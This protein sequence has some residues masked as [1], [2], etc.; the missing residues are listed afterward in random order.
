MNDLLH[1]YAVNEPT[2]F[3]LSLLLILAV[4]F[5]FNRVWSVRNLDLALLL[6]LSPGLLLLRV[7]DVGA[8][9]G[10]VWLFVVSSLIL[11]RLC[12]D[13]FLTRRPRLEQNLNAPGL[14]FL[15]CAALAFLTTRVMLESPHASAVATVRSAEDLLKRV[16]SSTPGEKR[17]QAGPATRLLAAPVVPLSEVVASGNGP[18][19]PGPQG[20]EAIAARTL[21]ILCHAAVVLGLILLGRW[22]LGDWQLGLAMATLYLL[23]PCTAYDVSQVNHVLPAALIVWAFVAWKRPMVAGVLLGLACGTLFFAA[24]LLPL[25][26]A[27]Y[28]RRGALRFALALGLVGAVLLG[29][30]VLTSADTHSFTRQT[31]GSIDWS[32]LRFQGTEDTGFWSMYDSAYRIPVFAAFVIMLVVVSIWPRRK[33]LEHLMAHSAA[34]VV[35]TQFWYP[36]QGGVYVLWYL[37]LLLMVFF[38]PRVPLLVPGEQAPEH[39]LVRRA[40]P[41]RQELVRTGISSSQFFR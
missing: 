14:A 8:T 27:F 23:L 40:V 19:S 4:F 10:Y 25:W 17:T 3:Y 29:S 22:H 18:Q 26:A 6:S 24:F 38:R 16:D 31:I 9:V 41:V 36:Q 37:P 32:A 35:A 5:R 1:G 20:I 21:A 13:G 33:T 7:P 34:I 15:C 12:C 30:L 28:G 2:W 39:T 11:L